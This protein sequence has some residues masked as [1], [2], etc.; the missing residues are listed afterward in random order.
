MLSLTYFYSRDDEDYLSVFNMLTKH[1]IQNELL[2][3]DICIDNQLDIENKYK[4]K[5][6][7]VNIGPYVL[8]SP[9]SQMDLDIATNSA[10]DRQAK[11]NTENDEKY[12]ERIQSSIKINSLDKFSY[13]FSKYYVLII[14]FLIA[15]FILVP[16]LAPILKKTDHETAANLIYKG[17]RIICHQ[18]AFRS[19]YLFGEQPFYPRELASVNG[20]ITYEQITGSNEIDLN[21][22]RDF[23]GTDFYGFKIGICERCL[24]IYGS[25][26]LFGLLFQFTSKKI[27]KLP[28]YLWVIIALIPIGLDGFSQIPS[29]STGWPA[30]VPIRESTPLIRVLTGALFGIGTGWY[31][32]PLM[33]ESMKE[34]RIMLYRKFVIINKLSRD[35]QLR[36]NEANQ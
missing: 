35:K 29:L 22:A 8:N 34:T 18:L 23:V 9:F 19:F 26:I 16:V 24:A 1:C 6:P 5:T 13:F 3:V 25:L 20:F 10:L 28:W 31:M 2:F 21:Y 12:R 33:E 27:K 30:W 17:Y 15:I 14:S 32:Y 4:D 11:L 7:V 36:I